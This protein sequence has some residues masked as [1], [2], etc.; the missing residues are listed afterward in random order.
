M[1]SSPELEEA[2]LRNCAT[3][4]QLEFFLE[5]GYLIVPNA[6]PPAMLSRVLD[7]TNRVADEERAK[8]GKQSSDMVAAFRAISRDD[9]FLDL[10]DLPA[11]FPLLW[12]ILGWNIQVRSY[13]LVFVQLFE[14]YGTLIERYTAL[15]EKVSA[16]IALHLA[17]H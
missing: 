15:I 8:A 13:F 5:E 1:G 6:L 10:L 4:E 16:L 9:A 17:H 11:T 7:A 14:K 3:P 12:D 2:W